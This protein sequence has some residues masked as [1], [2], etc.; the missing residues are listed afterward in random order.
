MLVK[1]KKSTMVTPRRNDAKHVYLGASIILSV[2][3]IKCMKLST[4]KRQIFVFWPFSETYS[5]FDPSLNFFRDLT[6]LLPLESMA[7]GFNSLPPETLTVG[8]IATANRAGDSL[9]NPT[10]KVLGDRHEHALCSILRRFL[11]VGHTTLPPGTLAVS[12]YTLAPWSLTVA[13]W[14]DLDFF[15]K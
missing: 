15:L 9:H 12:C 11:A 14:S 6:L 10:A 4:Q 8:N 5:R 1:K 3:L 7:V 13:K 2:Q